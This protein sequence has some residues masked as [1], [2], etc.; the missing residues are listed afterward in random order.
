MD[1]NF[2]YTVNPYLTVDGAAA[3]LDF[4]AKAFGAVEKARM[5]AQDGKRLMHAEIALNGGV[6]MLSDN[7]PEFCSDGE[8]T[9][10]S[11]D[12]PAPV[13]VALHFKTPAD[14]DAMHKRATGAGAKSIMAPEDTFWNARFAVVADPFGHR[15]MFNAPLPAKA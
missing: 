1:D 10:P 2:N 6:V 3:A 8:V 15:W 4:Y 12:K 5:P 11:I 7:F 13:Q 9:L 14:V